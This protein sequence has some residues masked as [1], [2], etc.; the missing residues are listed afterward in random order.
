MTTTKQRFGRAESRGRLITNG[1][2]G[3]PRSLDGD[4]DVDRCYGCPAFQ[5]VVEGAD[6]NQWLQCAPRRGIFSRV[7]TG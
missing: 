5:A 2:V 3:C 7:F 1:R 6:G 4:V